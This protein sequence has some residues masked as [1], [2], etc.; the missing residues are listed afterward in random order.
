MN[1]GWK[2]YN[3]AMI[4]TC[5]PHEEV[6]IESLKDRSVWEKGALLA[7][8]TSN[9]DCD[10]KTE[11]W[12][13]IKDDIFDIQK[14]K[15][16]R[17]YEIT[18]GQR[19]FSC[20]KILAKD[21][22]DEI[23]DILIESAKE[24]PA[25]YRNEIDYRKM[26]QRI[27]LWNERFVVY[28]A[29]NLEEKLC[30]YAYLEKHKT[31]SDFCVLKVYPSCEKYSINAALIA[32]IL[33]DYENDLQQGHYICDGSRPIQHE[34][35]FQEYLEK[36]FGFRKAYCHLHIKYRF[37]MR[38]VVNTLY[39]IRTFIKKHDYNKIIHYIV[40]ILKMEEIVRRNSG[41]DNTDNNYERKKI[42]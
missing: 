3:H 26:C 35:N 15:S 19:N 2:Y 17:R 40:G 42:K 14:L 12:Y 33:K 6:N 24:Y 37:P 21:Y 18:K 39:V 16:K 7:R 29:F 20:K 11:F 8:W 22:V 30:G 38:L 5:A 28:G 41:F 25:K 34:T 31:Y 23:I 27:P 9:F 13:C 10:Y 32:Y 1:N 36:Y 4:P